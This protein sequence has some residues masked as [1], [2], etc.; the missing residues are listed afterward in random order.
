VEVVQ[1]ET[2]RPC[3][4][5]GIR[6]RRQGQRYCAPCAGAYKSARYWRRKALEEPRYEDVLPAPPQA[7]RPIG[8]CFRCRYAA[9]FAWSATEWRC[10]LCGASPA[11]R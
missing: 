7:E 11:L 3:S 9:W 1:S 8:L 10:A 5:C 2:L 4:H 6:P